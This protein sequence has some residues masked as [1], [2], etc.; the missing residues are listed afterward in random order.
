MALD[1]LQLAIDLNIARDWEALEELTHERALRDLQALPEDQIEAM[2]GL[3]A[4]AEAVTAQAMPTF[5]TW[6]H[7]Y[8][9][10]DP[11]EDWQR[12]TM[13]VLAV[14]GGRDT[15]VVAEQNKSVV[16]AAL[17][18]A[19]TDD[20]ET[21]LFE[22]ANH[23]FQLAPTDQYWCGDEARVARY[24]RLL[25]A[26]REPPEEHRA[27]GGKSD[28]NDEQ[29][30]APSLPEQVAPREPE[31]CQVHGSSFH[32]HRAALRAPIHQSKGGAPGWGEV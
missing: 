5:Q 14:F 29:C 26:V 7:F 1:E 24:H 25:K 13:P 12:L 20:A 27:G 4:A 31:N 22:E 28:N 11:A 32:A 17:K 30:G 3:E 9:T 8:L 6:M 18:R 19:P 2:G 10:H 16:D 23:F 21:V 15:Q